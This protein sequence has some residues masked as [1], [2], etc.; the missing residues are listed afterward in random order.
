MR[1]SALFLT[2]YTGIFAYAQSTASGKTK[3]FTAPLSYPPEPLTTNEDERIR[4]AI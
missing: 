4:A 1:I 3:M 2:I